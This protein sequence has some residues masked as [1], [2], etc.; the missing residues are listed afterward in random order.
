MISGPVSF[1]PTRDMMSDRVALSTVS[2]GLLSYHFAGGAKS[3]IA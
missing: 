3:S 1:W 2:I